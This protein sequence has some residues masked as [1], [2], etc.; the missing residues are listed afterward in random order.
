MEYSGQNYAV[1]FRSV[2]TPVWQG[3]YSKHDNSPFAPFSSWGLHGVIN[4]TG[5]LVTAILNWL[6]LH[7]F[8]VILTEP[9]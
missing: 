1:R 4:Y 8:M 7:F 6:G 5:H 3:S 9:W 2:I